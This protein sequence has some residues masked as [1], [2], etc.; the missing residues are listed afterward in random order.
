MPK[1][2]NLEFYKAIEQAHKYTEKVILPLVCPDYFEYYYFY[3][4]EYEGIDCIAILYRRFED[5][6]VKRVFFPMLYLT[7]TKKEILAD[8]KKVKKELESEEVV[9]VANQIMSGTDRLLELHQ[10]YKDL[11][12]KEWENV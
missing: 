1:L 9:R 8:L 2:E 11:T 7:M 4:L 3:Q 10:Q 6:T 5:N 12:G